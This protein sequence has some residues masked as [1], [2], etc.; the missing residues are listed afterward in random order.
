[1]STSLLLACA[2]ASAHIGCPECSEH[3]LP[4]EVTAIVHQ[5]QEEQ[6]QAEENPLLKVTTP[7]KELDAD[8]AMGKDVAERVRK[9]MKLSTSAQMTDRVKRIGN[10]IAAIANRMHVVAPWGDKRFSPFEY[11]FE[12]IEG[13]DINAFSLPGGFIF[14]YEGLIKYAET[15][16]ELAGVIAHEIAHAS[17]RHVATLQK[18][19]SKL[20][21][22]TIPLILVAL[23][24]GTDTGQKAAVATNLFETAIGSGWSVKAEEAADY[25]GL[26]YMVNSNYDPVGALTFMERLAFDA[27]S[28]EGIDWGIFRTHPPS[29]NRAQDMIRFLLKRDLPIHRSRTSTT[30]RAIRVD[31]LDGTYS[32]RL[33]G[34]KVV[35]MAGP[36][37]QARADQAIERLNVFLDTLPGIFQVSLSG[38]ATLKGDHQ[39]LIELTPEDA[40]YSKLSEQALAQRVLSEMKSALFDLR[41]RTLVQP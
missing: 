40:A 17:F 22:F 20:Q 36:T 32:I 31:E 23:L 19:S 38:T 5:V 41:R 7:K 1:M 26:N 13:E 34:E 15:D 21:S 18:E 16:H 29:K 33:L 37:S 39:P 12:V 28:S 6:K 10:E 9:E 14:V 35:T 24:S 8:V 4:P 27:G 25:G 30:F 3:A 2:L 11:S